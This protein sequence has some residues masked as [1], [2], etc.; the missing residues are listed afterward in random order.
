MN[1]DDVFFFRKINIS[2]YFYLCTKINFRIILQDMNEKSHTI[3][4]RIILQD[5][6]DKTTHNKFPNYS[7][8]HE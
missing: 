2:S 6:N 8:R 3:N 7:T 1:R 5:M 4:F